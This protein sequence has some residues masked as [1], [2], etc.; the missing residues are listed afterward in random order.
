MRYRAKLYN[1]KTGVRFFSY[2][3]TSDIETAIALLEIRRTR[4]MFPVHRN[5]E[6]L[7][8]TP[9]VDPEKDSSGCTIYN[10]KSS[11]LW[12]K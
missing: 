7:E 4:S 8:V 12:N 5:A 2:L 1:R 10:I 11:H 3:R 6:V 9:V